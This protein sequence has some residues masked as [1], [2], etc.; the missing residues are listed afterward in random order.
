MAAK[1][2]VEYDAEQVLPQQIA[3]SISDLGFPSEVM[4]TES[5][6]GEVQIEVRPASCLEA[7][8]LE[9]AKSFWRN[10]VWEENVSLLRSNCGLA[11][12]HKVRMMKQ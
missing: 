11:Q 9:Q 10:K 1:A 8:G 5:G 3:N 6:E 7:D 4:E 12:P 2:E